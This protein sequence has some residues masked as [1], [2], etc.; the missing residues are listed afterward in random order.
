[1]RSN[2]QF[3]WLTH[4]HYQ[5]INH[6]LLLRIIKEIEKLVLCI[7]SVMMHLGNVERTFSQHLPYALSHQTHMPVLFLKFLNKTCVTVS[8]FLICQYYIKNIIVVSITQ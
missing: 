7:Y 1:M 6:A 2:R 4:V 5:A 3:Y 8:I